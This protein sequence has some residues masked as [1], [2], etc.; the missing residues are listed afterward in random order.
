MA[1]IKLPPTHPLYYDVYPDRKPQPVVREPEPDH[2][3]RNGY[4]YVTV[5]N[6]HP[7]RKIDAHVGRRVAE[8]RIV[9]Y[10]KI[11]PGTHPCHWCGK[12]VTWGE[13]LQTDHVDW[14]RLNNTPDNLVPS[15][16]PCNFNRHNPNRP[17]Q[18]RLI[19]LSR[20]KIRL[21]FERKKTS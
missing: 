4:R 7:L 13:G 15:C 20:E 9:L 6:E 8:H 16:R 18:P 19:D 2:V 5:D 11:G 1:R 10:D 21:H 3:I 12:P 14:D 17:Q